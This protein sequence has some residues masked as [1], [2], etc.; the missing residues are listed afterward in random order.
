MLIQHVPFGLHVE[1]DSYVDVADVVRGRNCG[2]VCPSC[3]TPLI[4]RQGEQKQWHFAHASRK[5]KETKKDCDFSFYVSVR[6]MA[7]Q[8][9]ESGLSL[10]LPEY[11]KSISVALDR[12]V[13][14]R[15]V[16][17]THAKTIHLDTVSKEAVF[18]SCLVDVLGDVNGFPF[19]IYFTHP[20][21]ALPD[22]LFS[23]RNTKVGII[24]IELNDTHR[25]FFGDGVSKG[26]HLDRLKSFLQH[27]LKSKRWIFHPRALHLLDQATQ[28]LK[29][30]AA[31]AAIHPAQRRVFAAQ[32]APIIRKAARPTPLPKQ[33]AEYEC[34]MC[35]CK[36]ECELPGTPSCPKCDSHLYASRVR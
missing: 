3:N 12:A 15:T 25:L 16:F 21:R 5:V 20:N 30:A 13:L 23:P 10:D 28:E 35:R 6:M 17:I 26:K 4:A 14:E 32:P 7:R 31:N 29:A 19:V 27:D 8:V 22:Q 11:R 18:E 1:S 33:V 24:E 36:W 9:I 34:I 2:C